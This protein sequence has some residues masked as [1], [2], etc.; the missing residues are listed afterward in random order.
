MP[1]NRDKQGR[2]V[3][4]NPRKGAGRGGSRAG[5]RGSGGRSVGRSGAN[6]VNPFNVS[7]RQERGRSLREQDEQPYGYDSNGRQMVIIKVVLALWIVLALA[8]AFAD[9]QERQE[10]V[11]WDQAGFQRTPPDRTVDGLLQYAIAEGVT[12]SSDPV[13]GA[14]PPACEQIFELARDLDDAETWVFGLFAGYLFLFIA[15]ATLVASFAYQANRN[16]LTLKSEGQHF[17]SVSAMLWLFVPMFN[18]YKGSRIFQEIWKGSNPEADGAGEQW[19]SGSPSGIV[20]LWWIAF[21]VTIL[22]GPR[23]IR[24]AWGSDLIDDRL[25]LAWGLIAMDIFLATPAIF[26]YI[27]MNRI[28][29]RQ[30]KK[31]EVVGPHMAVPPIKTFS[32]D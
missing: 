21:A 29:E 8:T 16:L 15:L 4:P 1:S 23:T 24:W 25:S 32:L 12:C 17:S 26:A 2:P 5:V 20:T 22:L 6:L 27:A 31:Y 30:E 19:K 11:K 14:V 28:H 7:G 13:T 3:R 10:L 18:F 9:Y